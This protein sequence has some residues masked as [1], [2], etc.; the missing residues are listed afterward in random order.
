MTKRKVILIASVLG[1]GVLALVA[2]CTTRAG[3]ESA[4][5][6]F[7]QGQVEVKL[8]GSANWKPAEIG[9]KLGQKD[10]LR[11]LENSKVDLSFGAKGGIRIEPSSQLSLAEYTKDATLLDLT[12]GKVLVTAE[13]LSKDSKF[14]VK[15]PTAVASITGT[16]FLVEVA[17][18]EVKEVK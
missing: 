10:A 16:Q 6:T 17:P 12:M 9:M 11:T 13:K 8:N 4:T 5:I 2:G 15:T 14:E 18:E 1:L 7:I 3:K